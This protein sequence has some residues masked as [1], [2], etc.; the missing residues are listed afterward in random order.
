MG[1][2][3]GYDEAFQAFRN[4]E[5]RFD[6]FAQKIQGVYVWDLLRFKIWNEILSEVGFMEK[7]HS[8][9]IGFLGLVSRITEFISL[10]WNSFFMNPSTFG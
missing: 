4:L 6:L 2:N 3:L 9:N 5:H 1:N 7:A 8:K 10:L